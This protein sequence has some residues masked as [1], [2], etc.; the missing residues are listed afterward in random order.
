M[1]GATFL[2][3]D[4]KPLTTQE[5]ADLFRVNPATVTR[6]AEQGKLACFKTPGGHRRY[7]RQ[8]VDTLIAERQAPAGAA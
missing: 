2:D 3:M 5:V 6:W 1:Q 4:D 7:R 8:D